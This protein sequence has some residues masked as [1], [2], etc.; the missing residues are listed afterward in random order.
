MKGISGY[1]LKTISLLLLWGNTFFIAAGE[2]ENHK[3]LFYGFFVDVDLA[4]P[5]LS[6]LSPNKFGVNASVQANFSH[7]VFPI[8]EVGYATYEGAPD[9]SYI[10]DLI[11]QPDNYSYFINGTY[12]KVGVNFNLLAKDFTKNLIPIGYLGIRY[13]VSPFN[14]RIEN[15]VV[16]DFYWEQTYSFNAQGATTAQWA[17]FLAGV[18][19][20]IYKNICLGVSVRFKQ[21]L[22]IQEKEERNKII[23]QS[24]APGFGDKDDGKW[25]F[26]YTVSYFFPFTK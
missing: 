13:G 10:P 5:F 14:Y 26:R 2:K 6:M 17:E 24:Y 8:L 1:I 23:R 20:P 18:Q 3:R 11:V 21:F 25:S 15:L 19:T 4:E 16:K 12:Y 22:Y 7:T 9:Y